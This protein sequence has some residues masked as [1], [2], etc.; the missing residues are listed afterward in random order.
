MGSYALKCMVTNQ[1][2]HY[3]DE[4]IIFPVRR[5]F[6]HYNRIDIIGPDETEARA[7][8]S[9]DSLTRVTSHW[10]LVS[11]LFFEVKYE[12][13]GSFDMEDTGANRD[14]LQLFFR[15]ISSLLCET[16]EGDNGYHHLPFKYEE[17]ADDDIVEY[18]T[19]EGFWEPMDKMR[20]F[21]KVRNNTGRNRDHVQYEALR[22]AVVLK[23]TF[24]LMLADRDVTKQITRSYEEVG[25]SSL[26]EGFRLIAGGVY[27]DV[28]SAG[29]VE[30]RLIR[31]SY[32]GDHG[33]AYNPVPLEDYISGMRP[34][35]QMKQFLLALD[36]MEKKIEPMAYGSDDQSGSLEFA[37]IVARVSEIQSK[38]WDEEDE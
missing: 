10:N 6:S 21:I 29:V 32:D 38:R 34:F 30:N 16:K 7:F 37:K 22:F 1:T 15:S 12:D 20:V 31:P 18:F 19:Q 5:A 17:Q 35:Y 11:D 9:S 28:S 4:C 14:K 8:A 24:D 13:Y 25:N 3:G 26:M 23:S 33:F 2:I 36:D 27:P